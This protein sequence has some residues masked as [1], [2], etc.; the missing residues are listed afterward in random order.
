M[1]ASITRDRCLKHASRNRT[2]PQ[3]GGAAEHGI[4]V[5][6][7]ILTL[8]CSQVQDS[9]L[10]DVTPL[11]VVE[12]LVARLPNSSSITP[13]PPPMKRAQQGQIE[14][15]LFK[16]HGSGAQHSERR[17][18]EGKLE[19]GSKKKIEAEVQETLVGRREKKIS[20]QSRLPLRLSLCEGIDYSRSL[21]RARFV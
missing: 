3:S 17:V 1:R 10:L 4:A 21:S 6:V 20:W 11:L 5:E 8:K 7:A 12:M 18:D 2:G 9:L 19:D 15:K 13:P 14:A 16:K